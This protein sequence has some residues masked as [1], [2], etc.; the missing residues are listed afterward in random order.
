MKYS[1]SRTNSQANE[2]ISFHISLAQFILESGYGKSDGKVTVPF[3]RF[4]GYDRGEDGN[5]VVNEE[6]AVTVRRI[7]PN[8]RAATTSWS[9]GSRRR[10]PH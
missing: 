10:K 2:R 9:D 4:L 5:L 3:S 1:C 8:A 6:E 7:N